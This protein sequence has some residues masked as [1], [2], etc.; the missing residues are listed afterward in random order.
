MHALFKVETAVSLTTKMDSTEKKHKPL[1]VVGMLVSAVEKS[2]SPSYLAKSHGCFCLG[3]PLAV[4]YNVFVESRP[5][6]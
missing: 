4:K 3:R 2:I 1:V 5:F 6:P